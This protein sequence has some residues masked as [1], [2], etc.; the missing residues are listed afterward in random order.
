MRIY[1]AALFRASEAISVAD[2]MRSLKEAVNALILELGFRY[3][4]CATVRNYQGVHLH[5]TNFQT[6][7]EA[8]VEKFAKD[9][10]FRHDPVIA[11]SRQESEAFFWAND[12]YDLS[13][14]HHRELLSIR[15]A[16]DVSGGCCIPVIERLGG[17]PG[18]RVVLFVTGDGFDQSRECKL[19]LQLISA[20]IA[21]R[22]ARLKANFDVNDED[23]KYYESTGLL[24]ARE[25]TILSWVASGKSSWEIAQILSISEHTVNTH[26][27]KALIKLRA[28]NRTEA[29]VKAMILDE[30]RLNPK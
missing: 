3:I 15:E 1:E 25:R 9:G 11:R 12:I 24:S 13:N 21:A 29:V 2:G 28:S 22:L 6:W 10:L 5:E 18:N 4:T 20:Q 19:V 8:A 17:Q 16:N 7:P 23:V 26:I 30:L 27:E 14:P